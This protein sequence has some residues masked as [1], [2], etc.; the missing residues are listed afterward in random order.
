MML[1]QSE[2]NTV[3]SQQWPA[4]TMED[5]SGFKPEDAG[6]VFSR[7]EIILVAGIKPVSE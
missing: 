2:L 1:L 6:F 3:N 5:K 7:T 4:R